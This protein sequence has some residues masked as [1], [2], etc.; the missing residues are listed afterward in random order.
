MTEESHLTR[1]DFIRSAVAHDF[2][3]PQCGEE[4][5]YI[6]RDVKRRKYIASLQ[7]HNP[8][9]WFYL[10]DTTWY[11][12]RICITGGNLGVRVGSHLKLK[13]HETNV[14]L[15]ERNCQSSD[16]LSAESDFVVEDGIL[17]SS[18]T[19]PVNDYG[20]AN[21]EEIIPNN[22]EFDG[23]DSPDFDDDGSMLTVIAS[24]ETV[25][26]WKLRFF[27]QSKS[28]RRC[29]SDYF[30]RIEE[31]TPI[32]G[33]IRQPMNAGYYERN[34]RMHDG[35]RLL[36]AASVH[37]NVTNETVEQVR[38]S[39]ALWSVL[40]S[41]FVNRLTNQE[42][43]ILTALLYYAKHHG[44][45]NDTTFF[46][47][48]VPNCVAELRHN[49]TDGRKSIQNLLP[50][51]EVHRLA[52][53]FVFISI[54][55]I[56]QYHLA[57]GKQMDPLIDLK[58]HSHAGS[59]HALHGSSERGKYIAS[60]TLQK[61]NYELSSNAFSAFPAEVVIWSDGFD[62][63]GT[64]KN[65]G[66]AHVI[67]MS[68]GTP[69][70][71]YH[72]GCNTYLVSLGPS[73]GDLSV[74]QEKVVEELISLARKSSDNAFFDASSNKELAVFFRV[75]C[76]L[77]DRPER[78]SWLK[79]AYGNGKFAGRFGWAGDL[80]DKLVFEYLPSC[81]QCHGRRLKNLCIDDKCVDCANWDMSELYY[82]V[83]K[84]YPTVFRENTM[85]G[86]E[87]P[88]FVPLD[89][90]ICGSH[91]SCHKLCINVLKEACCTAFEMV[92]SRRWTKRNGSAY[93]ETFALSPEFVDKICTAAKNA[94]DS[95]AGETFGDHPLLV[96]AT[97]KIPGLDI[98]HHIDALMHLCFLGITKANSTDLI[99]SWLKGCRK[100]NAFKAMSTPILK[101]IG[102]MSIYWCNVETQFGGYVSENWIAYCRMYKYIH[103]SLGILSESDKVYKDPPG[104]PF[105]SYNLKE[106]KA[107]LQARDIN[108]VNGRSRK[109]E[110][111]EAFARF[112]MLPILKIPAIVE[113]VFS[114]ATLEEVNRL[115]LVGI[116]VSQELCR[117]R[118]TPARRRYRTSIGTSRCF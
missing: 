64:K 103:Q 47:L 18:S 101:A 5:S 19:P 86:N 66:S 45:E 85:Q 82:P 65:R 4:S 38:P 75:F 31:S 74:V 27:D 111:E 93:L 39:S 2:A 54:R 9:C 108:G 118:P 57:N 16:Y 29:F 71:D 98:C 88:Q 116:H 55:E 84:D 69:Q 3:C 62:P 104:V 49:Y 28:P 21:D 58:Y 34:Y 70:D 14:T 97:W 32:P 6:N 113:P 60:F 8:V 40:L 30:P 95:M 83:P 90:R 114:Q 78:C 41:S 81:E 42:Q 48:A 13:S 87:I 63:S 52:D 99:N 23:M 72:S 77:Q 80:S 56:I 46:P 15:F 76:T 37:R 12:C 53:G 89:P 50:R 73:N 117:L 44:M 25:P 109:K 26:E 1:D 20:E 105:S 106:K 59:D 22:M 102:E 92:K 110:V 68:F 94:A 36:V 11:K 67:I 33:Y 96:P 112:T 79:L 7:C 35:P 91:L 61:D 100:A 17:T 10:K 51:P 24:P 115:W 43:Q 107:W